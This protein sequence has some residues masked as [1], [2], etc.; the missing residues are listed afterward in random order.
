MTDLIS[1][2]VDSIASATRAPK[3]R[4]AAVKR[5]RIVVLAGSSERRDV[6]D[7]EVDVVVTLDD[8][9]RRAVR[10]DGDVRARADLLVLRVERR[11]VDGVG[12]EQRRR[13]DHR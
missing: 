6:D 12:A 3:T 8:P 10:I 11:R 5:G 13:R 4:T 2:R 9:D 7:P 1:S